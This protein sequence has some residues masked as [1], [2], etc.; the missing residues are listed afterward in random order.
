MKTSTKTLVFVF[1]VLCFVT[2]PLFAARKKFQDLIIANNLQSGSEAFS[3]SSDTGGW[4]PPTLASKMKAY[5]KGDAPADTGIHSQTQEIKQAAQ[6]VRNRALELHSFGNAEEQHEHGQGLMALSSNPEQDQY[7]G[8]EEF[9]PMGWVVP[10]GNGVFRYWQW[11]AGV[12]TINLGRMIE[13][14]LSTEEKGHKGSGTAVLSFLAFTGRTEVSVACWD[15]KPQAEHLICMY[16]ACEKHTRQIGEL[17]TTEQGEGHMR[18]NVEGDLTGLEIVVVPMDGDPL[19]LVTRKR[20]CHLLNFLLLI[21]KAPQD[22]VS[23]RKY[24]IQGQG[25]SIK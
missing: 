7:S 13:L 23:E 6:E 5:S 24:Y 15:L 10:P 22:E 21:E 2:P 19:S 4:E 9:S 3:S 25:A 17:V 16:D 14:D 12:R 8:P 11:L 1:V 20:Q 18:V